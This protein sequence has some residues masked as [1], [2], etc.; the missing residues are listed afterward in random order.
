MDH[1]FRLIAQIPLRVPNFDKKKFLI[2]I[3]GSFVTM[4]KWREPI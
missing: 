2:A 4:N 3:K 1:G